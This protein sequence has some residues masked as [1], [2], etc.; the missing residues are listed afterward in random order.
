MNINKRGFLRNLTNDELKMFLNQTEWLDTDL[1]R[2]YYERSY[3]GRIN[4]EP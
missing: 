3:D 1:L 4:N 2:E